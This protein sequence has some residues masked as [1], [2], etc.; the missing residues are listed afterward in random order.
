MGNKVT[1]P[2]SPLES[3]LLTQCQAA[4]LPT[5]ERELAF[6]PKRRWRFDLAWPA[7]QLAVEI[8][9]GTWVNG[10][11]SRGKG[12]ENDCEK[13]NEAMLAGW[14]LLRVT[15]GMIRDGRAVRFIERALEALWGDGKDE[16]AP[17]YR[18]TP[19]TALR[20]PDRL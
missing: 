18:V 1:M 10:R 13:G 16:V 17:Y 2:T 4:G 19:P 20:T 11:H 7:P 9:G 14:S 6:H 12:F 5:P 8:E 3:L 15:E